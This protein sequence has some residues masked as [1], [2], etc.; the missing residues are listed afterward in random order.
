MCTYIHIYTYIYIYIYTHTHT[1]THTHTHTHIHTYTH[2]HTHITG[3]RACRR[4]FTTLQ[5]KPFYRKPMLRRTTRTSC[6]LALQH[7]WLLWRFGPD[8]WGCLF[9]PLKNHTRNFFFDPTHPLRKFV[10]FPLKVWMGRLWHECVYSR[11][12]LVVC[13]LI[14]WFI[15]TLWY[16]R[17]SVHYHCDQFILTYICAHTYLPHTHAYTHTI[18]HANTHTYT[19][20]L[21]LSLL[22]SHSHTHRQ[23]N[24]LQRAQQFTAKITARTTRRQ[25]MR[26]FVRNSVL[27]DNQKEQEREIYAQ[28]RAH[29]NMHTFLVCTHTWDYTQS[30]KWRGTLLTRLEGCDCNKSHRRCKLNKI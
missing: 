4:G 5:K 8:D 17:I 6:D 21:T 20:T 2:T 22:R 18:T 15:L 25:K 14:L 11:V 16:I 26:E 27:N 28:V 30:A 24:T 9:S 19:H 29:E 3:S 1:N 23:E 12:F 10:L 13:T 7:C